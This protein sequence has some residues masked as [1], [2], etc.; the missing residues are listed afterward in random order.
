MRLPSKE[1][2]I[3]NIN[4]GYGRFIA[5]DVY[6]LARYNYFYGTFKKF[7]KEAI[8]M[9]L[10]MMIIKNFENFN[11]VDKIYNYLISVLTKQ[12]LVKYICS[13]YALDSFNESPFDK[14]E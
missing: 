13:I 6:A 8:A 14:E 9:E 1:E 5:N 3:E 10:T 2:L 4:S 11:M 12:Q 7:K